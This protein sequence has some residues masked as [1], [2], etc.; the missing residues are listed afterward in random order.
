MHG[1]GDWNMET[2]QFC[3][4]GVKAMTRYRSGLFV[5]GL[6]AAPL[7]AAQPTDD[8]PTNASATVSAD[9]KAIGTAVK[10]DAKAVA[11]AAKHGAQ[12]VA[13]AAKETA[14]QVAVK[15]KKGAQQVAA[16]AKRGAA[17]AKADH[18]KDAAAQ[19]AAPKQ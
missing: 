19:P 4:P 5:L 11:Q 8:P 6:A 10:R 3:S 13:A 12:H 1:G 2:E 14:H 16:A 15:T 17:K 18:G 9:A 7:L